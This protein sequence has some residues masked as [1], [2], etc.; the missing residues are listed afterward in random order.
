MITLTAK[1]K[2][3]CETICNENKK[4]FIRISVIGGGCSGLSYK[5][6]FTEEKSKDYIEEFKKFTILIDPKSAIYLKDTV[7]DFSDGLNGKGFIF[8]NPNA[9]NS[10]G[11]GESFSV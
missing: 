5:I 4:S 8:Q 9:S 2:E 6:D 7:L 10:C 1:A 3:Q 11:C